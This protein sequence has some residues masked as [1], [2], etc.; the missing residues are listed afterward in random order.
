MARSLPHPATSRQRPQWIGPWH[1]LPKRAG[2]PASMGVVWEFAPAAVNRNASD[3]ACLPRLIKHSA[4]A[5]KARDLFERLAVT[6]LG[7]AGLVQPRRRLRRH[8]DLLGEFRPRRELC[9][10]GADAGMQP[11]EWIAGERKPVGVDEPGDVEHAR[12]VAQQIRMLGEM[13]IKRF[14]CGAELLRRCTRRLIGETF[15]SG[16]LPE[17]DLDRFL[18]ILRTLHHA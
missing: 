11:R 9:E 3:L 13:G 8:R 10:P 17:C 16:P 18:A 15:G 7:L 1:V 4:S 2:F 5:S 12:G 6:D 14:E